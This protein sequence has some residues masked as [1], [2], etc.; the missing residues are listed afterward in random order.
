MYMSI[1]AWEQELFDR[2]N[3]EFEEI[4]EADLFDTLELD[5]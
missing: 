3:G 2:Y 1:E 5:A 4:T